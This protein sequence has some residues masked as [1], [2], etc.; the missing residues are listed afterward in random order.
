MWAVSSVLEETAKCRLS[1]LH[2][3]GKIIAL[4]YLMLSPIS[5]L[6]GINLKFTEKNTSFYFLPKMGGCR[7][8]SDRQFLV[9]KRGLIAGDHTTGR[10]IYFAK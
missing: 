3:E 2:F 9:L 7:D 1:T 10:N 5:L 4:I 6:Y 8:G